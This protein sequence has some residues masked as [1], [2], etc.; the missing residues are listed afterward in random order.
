MPTRKTTRG[1]RA[2][3]RRPR[4]AAAARGRSR[5]PAARRTAAS[6]LKAR[7]DPE[8]LRLRSLEPALTVDDVEKSRRFYVDV[9][10]FVEGERW[11][12]GGQLRGLML[13]A[14]ACQVGLSQD[15]W[16]KGRGRQKGV[17]LS[18]WFTTAQDV[19]ALAARIKAQGGR[20][21]QEPADTMGGRSLMVEDPD[22]F[23]IR[24]YKPH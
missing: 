2:R 17:G 10:G 7:R 11:V 22:G 21:A 12:E 15:D 23:R 18:L 1:G 14:G 9:L 6:K 24:I 19:D 8:T 5:Q 4:A 16:S 20:L 3:A 13:K